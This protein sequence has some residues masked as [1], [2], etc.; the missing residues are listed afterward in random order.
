MIGPGKQRR[1]KIGLASAGR[2]LG[3]ADGS[4]CQDWTIA[5]SGRHI[6]PGYHG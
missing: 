3:K 4:V 5:A 6:V 1:A 2:G